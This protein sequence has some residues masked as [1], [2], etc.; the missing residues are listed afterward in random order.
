MAEARW[1]QHLH[2]CRCMFCYFWIKLPKL[3]LTPY[4]IPPIP[5]PP[6]IYL[7]TYL[8]LIPGTPYKSK[9][10]NS[11]APLG[12]LRQRPSRRLPARRPR[13]EVHLHR[14]RGGRPPHLLHAHVDL[15]PV[16][17][18]VDQQPERRHQADAGHGYWRVQR[19]RERR[20]GQ[21]AGPGHARQGPEQPPAGYQE[22]AGFPKSMFTPLKP[23]GGEMAKEG[24]GR[25][26]GD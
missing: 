16:K 23:N 2:L 4:P 15:W 13:R 3:P 26:R 18:D 21:A 14:R 9:K 22:G 10:T 17:L 5:P 11:L 7:P 25:R 20:Q 19:D 8:P 1:H 12:T 6:H 24:K